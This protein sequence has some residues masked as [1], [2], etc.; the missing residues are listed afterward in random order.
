M[1]KTHRNRGPSYAE[2][3]MP[4]EVA[5]QLADRPEPE[6]AEPGPAEDYSTW[7]Y[8]ELQAEAK[9]RGLTATGSH[10][11]LV[12]RLVEHDHTQG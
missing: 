3:E 5:Q 8:N 12:E 6:P 10:Q 9:D 11:V 2:G 4:E 1:P 7:T